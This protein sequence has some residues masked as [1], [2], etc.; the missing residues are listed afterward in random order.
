MWPTRN[1]HLLSLSVACA[2]L[3]T[4]VSGCATIPSFPE[5]QDISAEREARKEQTLQH[6]DR[7][8]EQAA[9]IEKAS[10]AKEASPAAVM[11]DDRTVRR[12]PSAATTGAA[13]DPSL[14]TAAATPSP[15][16][17]RR[18]EADQAVGDGDLEHAIEIYRQLSAAQ[19]DDAGL[20]HALA[21]VAE[22]LELHDE[23][24]RHYLDAMRLAPNEKLYRLCFE[25]HA[26]LLADRQAAGPV[27]R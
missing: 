24:S 21:V 19:P 20:H 17:I 23:A 2:S 16:Q 15:A 11:P 9:E 26:D 10:F 14:A 3:A 12:L 18:A 22:Q 6:I 7:T 13:F 1:A 8:R 5:W 25:A 4:F 27:I